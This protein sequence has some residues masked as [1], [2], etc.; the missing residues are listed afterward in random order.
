M[1]SQD[2]IP[3]TLTTMEAAFTLHKDEA[4]QAEF[5]RHQQRMGPIAAASAGFVCVIGGPIQRSD[6]LYFSGKWSTPALMDKWQSDVKHTPMQDA[7]HSRWFA[8]VYLRKWRLPESGEKITGPV[9][10]ELAI[11]RQ[12]PLDAA[13]VEIIL[14]RIVDPSLRRHEPSSFETMTGMFESQ[15]YQF[16]GPVL[17]FP[18]LAP[19][20]YLLLTHWP[21]DAALQSW[22]GSGV[23]TELSAYG[24]VS[25]TVSVPIKHSPGERKYLREDGLQRDAVHPAS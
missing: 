5:W 18:A 14:E 7:A 20:R 17:E 16:V 6:W 21:T 22:L 12:E 10:C 1:S 15:P 3:Q 4:V 8:S 23:T 9:F 2:L 24:E 19:A 13:A 25:T 11:A